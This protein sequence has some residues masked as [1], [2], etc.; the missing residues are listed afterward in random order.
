MKKINKKRTTIIDILLGIKEKEELRSKTN[1]KIKNKEKGLHIVC[2]KYYFDSYSNNI[3]KIISIKN[4]IECPFYNKNQK[5]FK[6]KNL[7]MKMI[8]IIDKKII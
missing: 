1:I 4:K 8:K 2:N 3:L 7:K 5:R 6:T